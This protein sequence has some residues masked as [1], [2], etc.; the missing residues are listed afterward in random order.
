LTGLWRHA[1]FLKLWTGQTISGFGSMIGAAAMAFTAIQ[2]LHATAFQLG[3]LASAR[4]A[5]GFLAGLAAGAWVDRMRRRP[6]LIGA[7]IG[8]ALLLA[9]IPLAAAF[10][11]LRIGQLYLV[12]VLV[13][14]LTVFF[15][16]AY[17]SWLPSLID[18]TALVERNSKLSATASIAEASGLGLAGWL[19]EI[20][21][22]PMT[23]LLDAL[24][25]VASA[26]SVWLIRTPEPAAV[27]RAHPDMRLEIVEGLHM[28]LRQP[29]LRAA[30]ACSLSR[31]FFGGVFGA[32]V[33]LY[34]VSGLGFSL[35]VLGSI[36][37][38]GGISAFIGAVVAGRVT[39]R[40]GIGPVMMVGLLVYAGAMFLIPLARGATVASA[41]LLILQ[42]LS[43]DG[44]A[45]VYQINEVSL[46]Q[47]IAPEGF[48]GR[49]NASAQFIR[50]GATLAGSLVGGAAGG[51][52]GVRATL[53]VAA[54]GTA[55]S[56]LWLVASPIR[57]LRTA[58]ESFVESEP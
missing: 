34:M 46:R 37:A 16:V 40:F 18:R 9:T 49:V 5:P 2:Y 4:V 43:G 44:A 15:D 33:M 29:L 1:D 30:A 23:I 54:F 21:T 22:A 35:G 39:K 42:Q 7:D 36:W 17:E 19:V 12:T 14:I 27:T 8:R 51:I 56:V 6:I 26:I 53:F 58:P 20:F 57:T 31:E 55:A 50:L 47:A 28:V 52:I 32:L 11:L 38:V 13:G 10:G 25:F 41:L 3:L 48:M 45:T 24:S